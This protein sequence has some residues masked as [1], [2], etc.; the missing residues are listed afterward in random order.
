VKT[1]KSVLLLALAIL[2]ALN[3]Y[4]NY[5]TVTRVQQRSIARPA[6]RTVFYAAAYE[7]VVA[8]SN[9]SETM[10]DLIHGLRVNF[11]LTIF[12][13]FAVAMSMKERTK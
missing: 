8:H 1:L 3:S 10:H 12:L 9:Q 2:A 6:Q 11:S 7:P 13:V 5:Q 4:T